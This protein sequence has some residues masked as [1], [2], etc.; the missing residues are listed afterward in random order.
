MKHRL[1]RL[2]ALHN[3]FTLVKA[4]VRN[5]SQL[6][7]VPAQ[8]AFELIVSGRRGSTYPNNESK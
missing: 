7:E 2:Q 1:Q 5:A 8:K 6:G 4:E 3:Y